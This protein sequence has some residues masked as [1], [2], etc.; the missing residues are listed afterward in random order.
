MDP[1][2]LL[3]TAISTIAIIN[4]VPQPTRVWRLRNVEGLSP[5]TQALTLC[6]CVTWIIYGILR[7]D[8]TQV[9]A[10]A[11]GL[12]GIVIVL[13]AMITFGSSRALRRA[14][15]PAAAYVLAVIA[16][17]LTFGIT[18]VAVLGAV[19]SVT[20]K[21][22]QAALAWR[23][24]GGEGISVTSFVI[25]ALCNALW[26][27]YALLAGDVPVAVTSC[28]GLAVNMFVVSRTVMARTIAARA[29]DSVFVAAEA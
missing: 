6:T 5:S 24:P 13:A 18:P 12:T 16:M 26:F 10:N 17:A 20:F 23:E 8:P 22:P 7:D 19:L 15:F 9:T 3:G 29:P 4:A 27:S 21:L 2:I 14:L 28:W 25:A 11:A 1:L